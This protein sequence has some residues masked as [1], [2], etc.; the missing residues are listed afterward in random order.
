VEE[1]EPAA[2]AAFGKRT[3][4]WLGL[5]LG[6]GLFGTTVFL[7]TTLEHGCSGGKTVIENYV[8]AVRGGAAVTP[9]AAGN[10]AS[11]LTSLLRGSGGSVSIGNFQE[12]HGTACFWVTLRTDT[13]KSEV[14][15]LLDT[16]A[17]RVVALSARRECDC[18][19]D[20]DLPCRLID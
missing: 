14:R 10:E 4:S 8:A 20:A 11:A 19:I 7:A 1:G 13:S 6:L 3:H 16:D 15:F 12:Q 2:E 9:A 17:R 5:T 18:P